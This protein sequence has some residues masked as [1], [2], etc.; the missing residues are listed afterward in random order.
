[1]DLLQHPFVATAEMPP[2]L[3]E[4]I[5]AYLASRPALA[6]DG[7]G[8][9]AATAQALPKWDFGGAGAAGA[10]TAAGAAAVMGTV[11]AAKPPRPS[12]SNLT[13]TV[14]SRP[15]TAP[16]GGAAAAA[17]AGFSGTIKAGPPP[18]ANGGT[19]R[20]LTDSDASGTIVAK[21]PPAAAEAAPLADSAATV[22]S[23]G[24]GQQ[25]RIQIPNDP[26]VP[27]LASDGSQ[28]GS[29]AAVPAR[30]APLDA[31]SG[32]PDSGPIRL[33]VQP[34]LTSAAGG[35]ARA[36]A[37]AEAALA[38]LSALETAQPGA[39]RSALTDMLA[40]LSVSSSPALAPL[41]SSAAAVFGG[42]GETGA[43]ASGQP[44]GGSSSGAADL[45]PLGSFL[46][47]TWRQDAARERA[48]SGRRAAEAGGWR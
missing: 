20:R 14:V 33:L 37:A 4:R 22:V 5:A 35:S 6:P 15:A 21:K 26:R 8:D 48:E 38:A 25:R 42:S 24:Q 16:D 10:G 36:A 27:D 18:P 29:S 19:L 23:R 31:A 28:L 46:L 7:G 17:A 45:G 43:D 47:E 34:A 2:E 32:Q 3:Q 39:T 40:L 13:G 1:M 12:T 30:R 9:A 44:G 41:K 11:V